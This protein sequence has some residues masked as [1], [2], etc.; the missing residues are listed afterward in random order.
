MGPGRPPDDSPDGSPDRGIV[1]LVTD[2]MDRSRLGVALPGVE[3]AGD[4]GGCADAG[5]VIVDLAARGGVDLA[6]VRAAAPRARIVAFGP[7]VDD[8]GLAR[9]RS[10][11]ADLVLPRSR[12]FHDPAAAVATVGGGRAP[13]DAPGP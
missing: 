9:G 10:E 7:H 13:G 6:A 4:P 8:A 11:G 3:F 12:F 1:A 2:L 5:V